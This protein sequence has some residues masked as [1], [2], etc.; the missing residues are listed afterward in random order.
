MQCKVIDKILYKLTFTLDE[1]RKE[2][3][4]M[5]KEILDK[6]SNDPKLNMDLWHV[7][8]NGAVKFRLEKISIMSGSW[9]IKATECGTGREYYFTSL[10]F[11]RYVFEKKEDAEQKSQ[12]V[13]E[14]GLEFLTELEGFGDGK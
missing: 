14:A 12:E 11:G 3:L 1:N 9:Y 10:D 7:S 5:I 4:Q 2:I 13:M 6:M 8:R